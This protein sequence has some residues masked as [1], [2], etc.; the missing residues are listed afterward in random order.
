MVVHQTRTRFGTMVGALCLLIMV[1]PML[2]S[3]ILVGRDIWRGMGVFLYFAAL[4]CLP[5][6]GSVIGIYAS[7]SQTR[8]VA[9]RTG[10]LVMLTTSICLL[11][12]GGPPIRE[13]VVYRSA[14]AVV[15][16]GTCG[17]VCGIICWYAVR[18]LDRKQ[19]GS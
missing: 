16:L 9:S 3:G 10:G 1:G 5:L 13:A 18:W 15:V 6:L 19:Q 8:A 4:F 14:I 11:F 12:G 2:W 17:S 7:T